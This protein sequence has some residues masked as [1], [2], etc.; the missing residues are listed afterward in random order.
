MDGAFVPFHHFQ[1]FAGPS[2]CKHGVA[3]SLQTFAD[4]GTEWFVIFN[5]DD[6]LDSLNRIRGSFVA[7][8]CVSSPLFTYN[9]QVNLKRGALSNV[10]RDP[11]ITATL[12]NDSINGGQA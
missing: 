7:F 5:N 1:R 3:V 10:T 8:F 12:F 6:R 9:W 11:N 2:C 4:N